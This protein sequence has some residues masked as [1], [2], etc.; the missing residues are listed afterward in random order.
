MV[1]TA[2]ECRAAAKEREAALT[3]NWE[4]VQRACGIFVPRNALPLFDVSHTRRRLQGACHEQLRFF[5]I[6]IDYR[7]QA[8]R[9]NP[10]SLRSL[11]R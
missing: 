5:E 2:S 8:W 4:P 9:F 7:K 10:T 11:P 3:Q 6:Q 1:G